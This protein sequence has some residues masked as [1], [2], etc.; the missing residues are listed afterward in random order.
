MKTHTEMNRLKMIPRFAIPYEFH[1][2][3]TC[4][5]T[6]FDSEPPLPDGFDKI[7]GKGSRFWAS[8]GRQALWL[9]LKGLQ[10]RQGAGVAV[11][12]CGDIGVVEAVHQAGYSPV[13]L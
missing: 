4:V 8:S 11:P 3:W 12:L 7:L 9:I 1:D 5:S 2:F 6:L 13:F 10:L